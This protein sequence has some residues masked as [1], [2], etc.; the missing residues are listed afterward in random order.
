[1]AANTGLFDGKYT[2]ADVQAMIADGRIAP[3]SKTY[4]SA[5]AF[6]ELGDEAQTAEAKAKEAHLS[7]ARTQRWILR[8]AIAA[9]LVSLAA[10]GLSVVAL[11]ES[12]IHVPAKP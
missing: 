11:S 9:L 12:H 5:V 8:I 1:M 2:V 3:T 4:R 6:M 7:S 10:L